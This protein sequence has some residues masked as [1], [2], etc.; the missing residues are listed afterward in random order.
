MNKDNKFNKKKEDDDIDD[1]EEY[2]IGN[3]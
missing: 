1:F 2:L 3:S